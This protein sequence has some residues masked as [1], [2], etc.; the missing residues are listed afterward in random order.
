MGCQAGGAVAIFYPRRL[1]GD[2]CVCMVLL[3]HLPP[4]SSAAHFAYF[5]PLSASRS[6]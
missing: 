3:E 2:V 5:S 4:L 6:S 1:G